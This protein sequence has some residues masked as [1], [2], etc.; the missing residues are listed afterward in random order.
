MES[1]FR[2]EP[3]RLDEVPEAI[4]DLVAELAAATAKLESALAPQTAQS[5]AAMVRIM[6]TYYSNLIEGNVT[7]PRDI[8][9]ALASGAILASEMPQTAQIEQALAESGRANDLLIEAVAHVRVQ[10]KIDEMAVGSQ[11]PE[12]ASEAFIKWLHEEFYLGASASMLKISGKGR[13]FQMVPG[14]WRSAAEQDVAVGRHLP[15]A[16]E[17]VGD[18]MAYFSKRYQFA[19]MGKAARILAIPAAHH[20]FNYVHPF[21]DGNGRVSRLMSHAMAHYA[22]IGA[23]G[24]WSISRGLARG[25]AS[26]NDYKRMMALADTPRQGDL[27]GRGN[28]SQKALVDFTRWFLQVCLDQVVFM[29]GLFEIETL[30]IRLRQCASLAGIKAD[31]ARLLDEALIRGQFDRGDAARVSGLP[32]RSARRV[33]GDL[34][35]EGLLASDTPKGPV[36]LRFPMKHQD[37]L[38]PRLFAET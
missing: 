7:R 10:A 20:R 15:P 35:Q 4:A 29:T 23:H 11:L 9:T 24:L 3:A 26:R 5:L 18:F 31:G 25:V 36:R 28:L 34:L 22:G 12:P 32:E 1:T 14:V 37:I 19:P 13:T 21:P 8:E 17:R 38:F 33:L 6:N 16:S 27:D 30:T 2:I